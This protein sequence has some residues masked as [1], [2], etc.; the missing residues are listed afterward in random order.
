MRATTPLPT[1]HN[2]SLPSLKAAYLRGAL[3]PRDLL[4]Q[5]SAQARRQSDYNAWI[6]LLDEAEMEPY[7]AALEGQSPHTLPLYGVPFA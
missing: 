6:C 2:L 7:L 3:N 1:V 4:R 5:L